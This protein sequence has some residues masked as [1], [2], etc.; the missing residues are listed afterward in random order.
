MYPLLISFLKINTKSIRLFGIKNNIFIKK[1]L[2]MM[3][4]IIDKVY[5][6]LI[7]CEVYPS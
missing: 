2:I 1:F 4:L 5:F 6:N 3:F 7:I